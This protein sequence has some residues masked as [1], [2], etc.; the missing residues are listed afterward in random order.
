MEYIGIGIDVS[1]GRSDIVFLNQSGTQLV[2]SGGY[3]DTCG[4]HERLRGV[5]SDLRTRFP[6]AR[7]IAGIEATGGLERTWIGFFSA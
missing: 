6:G 2:G 3:D 7:L 1:K 4:G 5:M